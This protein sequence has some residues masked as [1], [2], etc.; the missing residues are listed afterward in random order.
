MFN[1]LSILSRFLHSTLGI[2]TP[3][4]FPPPLDAKEEREAFLRAREG[5]AKA[6]EKL[7]VHNLRLVS[8]IVR[9]YYSAATDQEDLVSLGTVGLIKGVDSFD[10]IHGTRFATYA[11]KC[12][13]NEILMHFRSQKKLQNEVSIN[14]AIDTDRDGNPLTYEDIISTEENMAEEL[15]RRLLAERALSYINTILTS[16]ERQIIYLRYGLSGRTPKTQKE[17]A[18]KLAISRSYVS[19]IEKSALDKLRS[20]LGEE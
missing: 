20:A 9:K 11:A 14:E 16:R 1:L 7:I 13:Q 3:Q 2:A 10:P 18:E 19:R 15:D 5:D 6:R 12:I 8:H 17:T 4:G